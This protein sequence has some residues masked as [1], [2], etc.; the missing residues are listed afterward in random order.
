MAAAMPCRTT[1]RVCTVEH[2]DVYFNRKLVFV[3]LE[4]KLKDLGYR[5]KAVETRQDGCGTPPAIRIKTNYS[6]KLDTEAGV[7]LRVVKCEHGFDHKLV[8]E[9]LEEHLK[10]HGFLVTWSA[11]RELGQHSPLAIRITLNPS[12]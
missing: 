12:P 1:L 9:G 11:T 6:P 5:V 8:L 10:A 2:K 3:N 4:S 7:Q